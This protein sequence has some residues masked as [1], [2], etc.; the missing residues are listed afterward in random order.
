MQK[1]KIA[2]FASGS[3]SNAKAIIDYSFTSNYEVDVIISNKETAGVLQYSEEFDIDGY[4]FDM[5]G[6]SGNK[7]NTLETDINV[8]INP[9]G[10]PVLVQNTDS[11]FIEN[12]IVELSPEYMY[13]GTMWFVTVIL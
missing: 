3:G 13:C 9:T 8:T 6:T 2:I 12:S 1:T 10:S 4:T 5:T 11:I 7:Y